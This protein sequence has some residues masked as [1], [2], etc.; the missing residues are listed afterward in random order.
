MGV[1]LV[2]N[3]GEEYMD[4]LDGDKSSVTE[5]SS[6][7]HTSTWAWNWTC[8][9]F[10]VGVTLDSTPEPVAV[11]S[12]CPRDPSLSVSKYRLAISGVSSWKRTTDVLDL[13]SLPATS[14][15][16]FKTYLCHV[17][18]ANSVGREM[19]LQSLLV[20]S[21]PHEIESLTGHIRPRRSGSARRLENK[22]RLQCLVGELIRLCP[23]ENYIHFK[24]RAA[25]GHFISVQS[26]H[27][28]GRHLPRHR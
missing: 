3:D 21:D 16:T 28:I 5:L 23:I 27:G 7:R 9:S 8:R 4:R 24:C 25:S 13:F 2:F 15:D 20:K 26:S 6:G 14:E 18:G 12:I 11:S 1:D 22:H 10:K 17:P 19:Q